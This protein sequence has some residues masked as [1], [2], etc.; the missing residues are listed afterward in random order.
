[1]AWADGRGDRSLF[2]PTGTNDFEPSLA[3]N[4]DLAFVRSSGGTNNVMIWKFAGTP[5]QFAVGT[6]P[7]WS[8][9]GSRLAYDRDAAIWVKAPGGPENLIGTSGLQ[10]FHPSWSAEGNRIAFEGGV[11]GSTRRIWVIDVH[12]L[13]ENPVEAEPA[14]A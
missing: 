4:G 11:V 6:W 5:T 13:S 14:A 1:M 12:S 2:S 9:D 3:P 10:A 7:A 8:P